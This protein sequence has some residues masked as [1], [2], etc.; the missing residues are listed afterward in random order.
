MIIKN[1]G[2]KILII[3]CCL[4]SINPLGQNSKIRIIYTYDL[5]TVPQTFAG[6]TTATV[7]TKLIDWLG[8]YKSIKKIYI[9]PDHPAS[10]NNKKRFKD[11][12]N[13]S[14]LRDQSFDYCKLHDGPLARGII[15]FKDGRTITFGMTLATI[16]IGG[17][18]WT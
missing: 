11:R 17:L 2:I 3:S 1:R 6:D 5:S 13:R 14:T 18:I 4:L 9:I 7:D 8:G 12:L 15:V 16:R 10:N